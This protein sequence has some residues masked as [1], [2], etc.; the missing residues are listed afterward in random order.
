MKVR[1]GRE[2]KISVSAKYASRLSV[3]LNTNPNGL[4][5]LTANGFNCLVVVS[6]LGL[7]SLMVAG[8]GMQGR[9]HF[10]PPVSGLVRTIIN[11]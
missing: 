6:G 9:V 1:K 2:A 8:A 10:G 7:G 3:C 4:G 11:T 5:Q